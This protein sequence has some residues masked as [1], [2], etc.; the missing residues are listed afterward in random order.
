MS[1]DL[2][3]TCSS[4]D[5]IVKTVTYCMGHSTDVIVTQI[6]TVVFGNVATV[7]ATCKTLHCFSHDLQKIFKLRNFGKFLNFR[8]F[9]KKFFL[10]K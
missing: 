10:S 8:K 1:S 7:V 4:A 3:G 9:P 2:Y 5:V 6:T